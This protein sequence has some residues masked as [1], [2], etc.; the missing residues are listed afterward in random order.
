MTSGAKAIAKL[1]LGGLPVI[2]RTNRYR[3]GT[4]RVVLGNDYTG[5][6]SGIGDGGSNATDG[7]A[8]RNYGSDKSDCSP[9]LAGSDSGLSPTQSASTDL[10]TGEPQADIWIRCGAQTRSARRSTTTTT[11]PANHRSCRGHAGQ[12]GRKTEHAFSDELGAAAQQ[13]AV[14]DAGRNGRRGV[15]GV[16]GIGAE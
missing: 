12:L 14:D 4:V 1:E 6:G 2:A 10:L 9:A 8:R 16:W 7:G 11:Q 15:V 5:P 13:V 3:R